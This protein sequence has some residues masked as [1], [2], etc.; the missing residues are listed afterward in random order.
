MLFAVL[1]V[2]TFG[3][4]FNMLQ[5]NAIS[6]VLN[7]SREIS[8]LDHNRFGAAV[9]ARAVRRASGWPRSPSSCCR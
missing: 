6:D 8:A 9:R 4:A 5:A 7:T 3:F 1:L 2:F